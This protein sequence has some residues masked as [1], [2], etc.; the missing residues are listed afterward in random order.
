MSRFLKGAGLTSMMQRR[1]PDNGRKTRWV[2]LVI[3]LLAVVLTVVIIG[4]IRRLGKP[5]E[6]SAVRLPCLAGQNVTPFGDYVLYYDG[7]SIHCITTSG[8]LRWS[9]QIGADASFSAGASSVVAWAGS[10]MYILDQ[11][12]HPSYSDNLGQQVQLARIGKK[13]AAAVIGDDTAPRLVIRDLNGAPVDEEVDAFSGR[14]MLDVGF[15]GEDGQYIWTLAL[16]VFGTV[17]NTVLNTFEVGQMNTGE[18]SLGEAINYKVLY[19]AQKLRIMT[20]RQL[21][22]FNYQGTEDTAAAILVYGWSLIA[23]ETPEKGDILMLLAPQNQTTSQYTIREIRLLSGASDRRYTLPSSC[24]GAAIYKKTVYAFSSDYIYR[25]DMG[26]QR[27]ST[28]NRPQGMEAPTDLIGMTA[29]GR[30]LLS[31]GDTVYAVTMP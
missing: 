17:A 31:C 18:I 2:I 16:D 19:D 23:S 26:A 8:T 5:S 28:L 9:Y 30:A 3:L 25:T 29:N 1:Q 6:S 24:V 13:Y 15:Y 12:G 7:I 4:A 10:Q 20:T 14:F 22:T 21:R 27:F 11:N